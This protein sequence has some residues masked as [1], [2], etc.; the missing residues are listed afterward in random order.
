MI[1]Y[2]EPDSQNRDKVKIVLGCQIMLLEK[3]SDATVV[4]G[5][6]LAAKRDFI[7]L[8]AEVDKLVINKLVTVPSGL[9]NLKTK[10][11]DLDVDNLKTMIIDSQL[12]LETVPSNCLELYLL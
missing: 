10:V 8:K 3:I 9:N 12:L 6:N 1:Y 2:A 7:A 4:N 11:D 5:S